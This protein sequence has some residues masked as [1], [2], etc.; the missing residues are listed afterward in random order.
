MS[1]DWRTNPE[2]R[3]RHL[4]SLARDIKA[5]GQSWR[6]AEARGHFGSAACYRAAALDQYARWRQLG[7]RELLRSAAGEGR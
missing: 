2:A 5:L 7:G 4:D 6:R 1:T 3:R